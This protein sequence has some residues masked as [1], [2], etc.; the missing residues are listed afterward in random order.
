MPL[1]R[2][3]DYQSV[4]HLDEGEV[5]SVVKPEDGRRRQAQG[6][7]AVDGEEEDDKKGVTKY[8]N[9]ILTHTKTLPEAQQP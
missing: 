9:K 8:Q 4:E 3:R 5:D 2:P 7:Q 1:C 6:V